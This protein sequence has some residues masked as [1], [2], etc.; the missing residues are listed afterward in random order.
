LKVKWNPFEHLG[1]SCTRGGNILHGVV[2]S[3]F[4]SK[5]KWITFEKREVEKKCQKEGGNIHPKIQQ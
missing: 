2:S 1:I 5:I 4:E 3:L